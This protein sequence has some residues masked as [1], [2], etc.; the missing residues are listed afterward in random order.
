MP[1]NGQCDRPSISYHLL[2]SF[3]F[4][5]AWISSDSKPLYP[6]FHFSFARVRELSTVRTGLP[7]FP[8][9]PLNSLY[10]AIFSPPLRLLRHLL[11]AHLIAYIAGIYSHNLSGFAFIEVRVALI[12]F[13]FFSPFFPPICLLLGV[14]VFGAMERETLVGSLAG[15]R[16]HL[17]ISLIGVGFVTF[18]SMPAAAF[19]S[20]LYLLSLIFQGTSL[21]WVRFNG[22]FVYHANTSNL[23][24]P[25][26]V[27]G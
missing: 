16:Q 14:L 1:W 10:L 9:L 5:I 7:C 20:V 8:L 19:Y 24:P 11:C 3:P 25:V 18:S 6:F 27:S 26:V 2:F 13:T 23:L 22:N 4:I 17:T 12:H 21:V 15:D